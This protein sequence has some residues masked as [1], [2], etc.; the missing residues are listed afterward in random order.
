MNKK[1]KP[2]KILEWILERFLPRDE[3]YEKLGDFEEAYC[4]I[5]EDRGRIN[6][7]AWY[8]IQIIKAIPSFV[9][10]SYYILPQGF[11]FGFSHTT[12]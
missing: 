7:A 12:L 8:L 10:N 6:A 11:R 4:E 1:L 2:P 3:A 5:L 9:S